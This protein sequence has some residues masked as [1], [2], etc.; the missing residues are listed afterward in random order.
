MDKPEFELVAHTGND[1]Y[2]LVAVSTLVGLAT[3][4][5]TYLSGKYMWKSCFKNAYVVDVFATPKES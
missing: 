5:A 4:T 2:K 3:A 1:W